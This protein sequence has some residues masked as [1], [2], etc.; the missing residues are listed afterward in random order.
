[1]SEK[2]VMFFEAASV[3]VGS[4][5]NPACRG[6]HIS[7]VD[8]EDVPHA[9]AVLSCEQIESFI[10]DLRVTRDRIVMGG[11]AKGIQ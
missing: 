2:P 3:I 8:G 4:C 6:V 1:M 9:H 10:D 5:K 7:L 11:D